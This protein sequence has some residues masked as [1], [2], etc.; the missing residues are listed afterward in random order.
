MQENLLNEGLELMLFGMG[1]VFVF[2]TVLVLVTML[3]SA[4]VQRFFPDAPEQTLTTTPRPAPVPASNNDEQLLAVIT[5]AVHK[6]RSR[7]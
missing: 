2:L 4:I 3:M 7:K 6:F 5:A 1:T